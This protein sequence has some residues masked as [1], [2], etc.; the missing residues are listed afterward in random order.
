MMNCSTN[1]RAWETVEAQIGADS[2]SKDTQRPRLAPRCVILRQ[3]G[4]GVF[5][6]KLQVRM[7]AWIGRPPGKDQQPQEDLVAEAVT[8]H[9]S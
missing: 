4:V 3:P 1:L 5:C 2:V 6:E 8:G 9:G 7:C